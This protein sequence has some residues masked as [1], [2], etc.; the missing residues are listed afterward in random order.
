SM[1]SN[2]A[3]WRQ[4]NKL[5]SSKDKLFY[6]RL[7]WWAYGIAQECDPV[8][9]NNAATGWVVMKLKS[10][11]RAEGVIRL[12]KKNGPDEYL[13]GLDLLVANNAFCLGTNQEVVERMRDIG[14][15]D[16]WPTKGKGQRFYLHSP[17]FKLGDMPDL[18][19]D[20]VDGIKPGES[21][22]SF[23]ARSI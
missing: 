5:G 12:F 15:L 6:Q 11:C 2:Y 4:K 9:R 19:V 3:P 1:N 8:L 23:W 21:L 14:W 13:A 10:E 7:D 16:S 22:R 17:I 20:I 18:P